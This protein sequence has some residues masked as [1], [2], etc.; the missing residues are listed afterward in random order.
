M[1]WLPLLLVTGCFVEEKSFEPDFSCSGA[2]IPTSL[3]DRVR[4]DGQLLNLAADTPLPGLSVTGIAGELVGS[5]VT[6]DES[7][8]FSF[9]HDLPGTATQDSIL[10]SGTFN[11]EPLLTTLGYPGKP[12][13]EDGF[14]ELRMVSKTELLGLAMKAGVGINLEVES[15]ALVRITDCNESP[16]AG[17]KLAPPVIT[18][19]PDVVPDPGLPPVQII[20]FQFGQ[21]EQTAME[22]DGSGLAIIVHIPIDPADPIAGELPKTTEVVINGTIGDVP[23]VENTVTPSKNTFVQTLAQP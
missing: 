18:L 8:R 1:R 6:S 2:P 23:F 22:S 12:V 7:G 17:A 16:V 15:F 11:G 19:P 9:S 4:V 14:V 10:A 3:P 13:F 21:L 5:P 20:Y